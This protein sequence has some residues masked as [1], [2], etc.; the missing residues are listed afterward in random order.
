MRPKCEDNFK[1]AASVPPRR[2]PTLPSLISARRYPGSSL[3]ELL[4]R[5]PSGERVHVYITACIVGQEIFIRR[6]IL[7]NANGCNDAGYE[8]DLS[9]I[10]KRHAN[11]KRLYVESHKFQVIDF[12]DSMCPQIFGGLRE[13]RKLAADRIRHRL[14]LVV[15]EN[16][17]DDVD[18]LEVWRLGERRDKVQCVAIWVVF[19]A[20]EYIAPRV[21]DVG[22]VVACDTLCEADHLV[23]FEPEADHLHD[24]LVEY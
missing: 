2:L 11:L 9:M 6:K 12:G 8:Y 1:L 23:C 14:V 15:R 18:L 3:P 7:D 19:K 17:E 5:H 24:H 4:E 13:T 16:N 20:H 21:L 22:D 10:T